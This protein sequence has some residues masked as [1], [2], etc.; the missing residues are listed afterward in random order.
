M[1]NLL[2]EFMPEWFN[3][4]PSS[5]QSLIFGAL[6]I[7]IVGIAFVIFLAFTASGKNSKPDFKAKLK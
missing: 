1:T 2:L 5:I 6:L 3:S 7:H 4:L